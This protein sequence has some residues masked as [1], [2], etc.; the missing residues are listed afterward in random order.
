MAYSQDVV[1]RHRSRQR[2]YPRS[3]S[4]SRHPHWD[5]PPDP[6]PYSLPYRTRASEIQRPDDGTPNRPFYRRTR[7]SADLDARHPMPPPQQL[8][9]RSA[10]VTRRPG[11]GKGRA[12]YVEDDDDDDERSRSRS[13]SRIRLKPKLKPRARSVST[14]STSTTTSGHS[15]TY[16]ISTPPRSAHLPRSA[17]VSRQTSRPSSRTP[18]TDS[19]ESSTTTEDERTERRA[20]QGK[21]AAL[22]PAVERTV[23]R[24]PLQKPSKKPVDEDDDDTDEDPV[25][26]VIS[27]PRRRRRH[28]SDSPSSSRKPRRHRHR[29]IEVKPSASTK[30]PYKRYYESDVV[31]SE[32]PPIS[33]SHTTSSSHVTSSHS[34]SSSSRRSSAFLNKFMGPSFHISSPE[35]PAPKVECVV[36]FGQQSPSQMA[37]LRCGHRMCRTCLKTVFKNS[38]KDPSQMPPRCC[39]S[40][41][42]PVKHV[43]SL[44][45]DNFKK[46]WNRKFREFSTQNRIYCPGKRCGE[47]IKPSQIHRHPNGRK[48]GKCSSCDTR[49]CCD[50]N[51]IWHK[52]SH[53]PTDEETNRVLQQAKENG[54][55]RCYDCKN[56]IELKEGCNHMTCRCGAQFCMV[57]GLEW[58]TCECPWFSYDTA[59]Q[60]ELDHMQTP[61]PMMDRDPFTGPSPRGFGPRARPRNYEDESLRRRLQEQKDEDYARRL[62]YE[63]ND[64]EY[65]AGMGDVIGIGNSAGHFMNDDYRRRPQNVS[66][67]LAPAPISPP[68]AAPF[69]RSN[70]GG[71]Y[72]SGVN[73]ARGLRGNSMERRLADRF[74]EQRQSPHLR[75]F[76]HPIPPPPA[77]PRGAFGPPPPPPPQ[78]PMMPISMHRRHTMD[79]DVYDGPRSHYQSERGLSRRA[80]TST[81]DYAGDGSAYYD[82]GRGRH[83]VRE[84]SPKSS[85]LAGLAGPG[86]GMNRVYEWVNHVVDTGDPNRPAT[87]V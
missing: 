62:Q 41:H 13:R 75:P 24:R 77:P 31:H 2:Y 6:I 55:Q 48:I 73:R 29:Y 14:D 59:E 71:D 50:C 35:K 70:A 58:K 53:C 25:E 5:S 43:D 60:D 26:E 56:M 54:W 87:V 79:D 83:H 18:S 22:P 51:N 66:I 64:D 3:P 72:V 39:T 46:T 10:T 27:P 30:R 86:S 34:V 85:V 12:I 8:V 4:P 57:C 16:V 23:R 36:C 68:S 38:I 33:R 11:K 42:I 44:F 61:D 9:S 15:D 82:P 19:E 1:G 49:V 80:T 47:W 67:P 37:K 52:S 78:P 65:P 81:R 69:D 63:E 21:V 76:T 28:H 20:R 17:T 40:D 32:R 84:P 45:D 74:S 7:L